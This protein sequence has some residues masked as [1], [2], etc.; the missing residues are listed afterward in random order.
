MYERNNIKNPKLCKRDEFI[1]EIVYLN[2]HYGHNY[3]TA[4]MS[5]KIGDDFCQTN[6]EGKIYTN[7]YIKLNYPSERIY[8][9]ELAHVV[10]IIS[11]KINE[12]TRYSETINA[13]KDLINN[14]VIKLEWEICFLFDFTF[15]RSYL[16]SSIVNILGYSDS[17]NSLYFEL[18][19]DISK[20]SLV[21]VDSYLLSLIIVWLF[22]YK[23]LKAYYTVRES[24]FIKLITLISQE[25]EIPIPNI[26]ESIN[27]L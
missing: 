5:I 25:Y 15:K 26:I 18:I 27:T 19:K 13:A 9:I 6:K 16:M 2:Q 10:T 11:A 14:F 4:L 23:K 12:D 1:N 22:K 21:T 20:L 3:D 24:K 7:K 17:K 8:S